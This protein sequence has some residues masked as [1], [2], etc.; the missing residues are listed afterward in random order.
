MKVK[1]CQVAFLWTSLLPLV[2]YRLGRRLEVEKHLAEQDTPTLLGMSVLHLGHPSL[3]GGLLIVATEQQLGRIATLHILK[4][5]NPVVHGGM[6]VGR[7]VVDLLPSI[8]LEG[9]GTFGATDATGLVQ[10]DL[11]LRLPLYIVLTLPVVQR[12]ILED[13]PTL[14]PGL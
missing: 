6:R 2:T 10:L 5:A 9:G 8:D 7:Q 4:H 14:A 1:Q 13:E 3:H 12:A 11:T